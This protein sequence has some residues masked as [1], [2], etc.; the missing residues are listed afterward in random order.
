MHRQSLPTPAIVRAE[1]SKARGSLDQARVEIEAELVRL[2]HPEATHSHALA[3]AL[4]EASRIHLTAGDAVR[5]HKTANEATAIAERIARS[6][7]QSA[8][9][10]EGLLLLSQAQLALGQRAE[11][12]NSARRAAQSLSAG[13]AADH[14]LAREARALAGM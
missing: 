5:A 11:S 10:G 2:A 9:A 13:L 4:R 7:G 1:L 8:D 6:A 14:R 3:A 12:A